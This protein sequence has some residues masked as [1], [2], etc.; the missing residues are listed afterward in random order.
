MIRTGLV[1]RDTRAIG[2]LVR[3]KFRATRLE[4]RG[5]T[6]P[7]NGGTRRRQASFGVPPDQPA[8]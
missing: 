7:S 5:A 1:R 4:L 3:R 8:G 2:G 6:K